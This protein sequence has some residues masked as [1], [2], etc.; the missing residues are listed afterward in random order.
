MTGEQL[1]N[2]IMTDVFEPE[3]I[4]KP[5]TVSLALDLHRVTR[6]LVET[7]NRH[8]VLDGAPITDDAGFGTLTVGGVIQSRATSAR[9][10]SR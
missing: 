3:P 1:R 7:G 6:T 9:R 2:R 4:M 10:R 8:F 5:F